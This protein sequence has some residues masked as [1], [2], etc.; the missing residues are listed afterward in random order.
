MDTIDLP[1]KVEFKVET[2]EGEWTADEIAT[3]SAGAPRVEIVTAWFE[4]S[5][6]GP[7]EITDPK[8]IQELETTIN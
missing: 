5:P 7:V 1:Y 8:R 2:Y 3:G 4:N 6:D